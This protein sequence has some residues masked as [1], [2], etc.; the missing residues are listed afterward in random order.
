M[1]EVFLNSV[2]S[3]LLGCV[4]FGYKLFRKNCKSKCTEQGLDIHIGILG[5]QI[6]Q[7]LDENKEQILKDLV[8]KLN[9][10]IEKQISPTSA[11]SSAVAPEVP[12]GP[13]IDV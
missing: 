1:N 11:R 10:K 2:G 5:E 4:Y 7:K 8:E 12:V 13:H 3:I 9:D 6:S